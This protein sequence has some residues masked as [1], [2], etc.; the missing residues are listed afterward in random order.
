MKISIDNATKRLKK[1]TV[2]DGVSLEFESGKVYGLCGYNGCGKTMLMRMIAGLIKPTTGSVSVDGKRLGEDID[3][4]ESIGLLIES[5][6]FLDSYTALDNLKLIASIKR[7][8]SEE[9]IR[10]SL[11]RVQL[12]P[13][14]IRKF[15]KFSLGM[16][17]RLGIAAAIMEKPDL[18]LLDEPTNALDVDGVELAAGIIREEK[19]RGALIILA[20]HDREFLRSAAD[21]VIQIEGGKITGTEEISHDV[22]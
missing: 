6:A 19:A 12:D 17:Q 4:P 22:D 14:D 9:E 18:L 13:D 15:K 7:V 8:V 5:P 11:E 16:K 2:I 3:F 21:V 10:H 20:C 1:A